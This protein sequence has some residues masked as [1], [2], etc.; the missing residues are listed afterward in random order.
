MQS[1]HHRW[2]NKESYL[3]KLDQGIELDCILLH[4]QK[5]RSINNHQNQK[6]KCK[7]G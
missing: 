1:N 4:N 5:S 6:T 2:K 3:E 7:Y